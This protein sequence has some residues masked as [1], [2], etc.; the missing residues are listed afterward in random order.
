MVLPPIVNHQG[1]KTISYKGSD[2][3]SI[4]GDIGDYNWDELEREYVSTHVPINVRWQ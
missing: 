2:I 3:T 4:F 1:T